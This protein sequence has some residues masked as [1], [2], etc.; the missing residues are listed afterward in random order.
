VPDIYEY[1]RT[2]RVLYEDDDFI[3]V[4][5]AKS[6]ERVMHVNL[7]DPVLSVLFIRDERAYLPWRAS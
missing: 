7:D 2:G 5:I 6:P 3:T 1:L 4:E